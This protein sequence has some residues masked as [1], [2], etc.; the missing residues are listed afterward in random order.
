MKGF[1]EDTTEVIPHGGMTLPTTPTRKHPHGLTLTREERVPQAPCL[2]IAPS[3]VKAKTR[4]RARAPKARPSRGIP[5]LKPFNSGH[6]H[7]LQRTYVAPNFANVSTWEV[8]ARVIAT[9]A[10][11]IAAQYL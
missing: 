6:T 2:T 4:A 7:G 9:L 5:L 10:D 8:T 11:L 3:E 1:L